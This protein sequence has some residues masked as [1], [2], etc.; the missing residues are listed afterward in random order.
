[1]I[2]IANGGVPGFRH[3]FDVTAVVRE[4]N[5]QGR[6]DPNGISVTF[7]PLVPAAPP[8][9]ADAQTRFDAEHEA[10]GAAT[11]V[12]IGLVSLFVG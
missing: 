9:E 11:P 4:L 5:E 6:W 7:A 8:D 2:P 1:M 12:V 3:T 10:M